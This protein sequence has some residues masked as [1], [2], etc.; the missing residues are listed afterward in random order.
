MAKWG[1]NRQGQDKVGTDP[2]TESLCSCA[3][4]YKKYY[5]FQSSPWILAI[6][7]FITSIEI[8]CGLS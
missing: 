1:E 6:L 3:P 5:K 2:D 4:I 8:I 7:A